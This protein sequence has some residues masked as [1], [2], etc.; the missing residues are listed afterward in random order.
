MVTLLAAR[1]VIQK[2]VI[3]KSM[4]A[5]QRALASIEVNL[6]EIPEG[7]VGSIYVL[8]VNDYF[9]EILDKDVWVAW[10]A[11]LCPSSNEGG[12][13]EGASS[14]CGRSPPSGNGWPTSEEAGV[15]CRHRRLHSF[16]LC[17]NRFVFYFHF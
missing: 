11:G 4:A 6:S 14:K 5:D 9:I 17:A 13:W 8:E 16:G 10:K 12:N 7:K 3:Y 15:V 2:I 1:E